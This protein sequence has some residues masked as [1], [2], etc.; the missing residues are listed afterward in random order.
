MTCV[1]TEELMTCVMAEEL[2]TCVMAEELMTCAM[3]GKVSLRHSNGRGV[4][5]GSNSQCFAADFTMKVLTSAS[6]TF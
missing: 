3:A 2:M 1:M 4:G 5:I 6:V